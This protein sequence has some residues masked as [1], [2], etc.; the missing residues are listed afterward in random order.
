MMSPDSTSADSHA[1]RYLHII[2]QL[3][4]SDY[5]LDF[6]EWDECTPVDEALHDLAQTLASR[7]HE[8][9]QLDQIIADINT[10][11]SLDDVLDKVYAG[12]RELIP[13]DR[14]SLSL[15]DNDEDGGPFVRARWARTDHPTIRLGRGY[16]AP[17]AG[18][19][20]ETILQSGE[21]RI[22]NDLED[23]LRHKPESESTRLIVEEGIR[24]SLTCPLTI[25]GVPVGFLFFSSNE[26]NTYEHD[27][28]D[29]FL[30]IANHLAISVEKSRLV[31][32][33]TAQKNALNRQNKALQEADAI[34]NMILGIA[35]H[36]L[37]S[38]L[39]VIEMAMTFLLDPTMAAT[40][41]ESSTVLNDVLQQTRYMLDLIDELLDM[42]EVES[43][44]LRL[45]REPV[46]VHSFLQNATMRHQQT[47]H[48]KNMT[49][50]FSDN[51]PPDATLQADPLRLRQVIDNL[52]S[53]AIKYSPS[54]SVIRVGV[55]QRSDAWH[56]YV[57]D[58]GPG[59][60]AADRARLFQAFGRLSAQPT[61]G[62]R[63]TGL[64]LAIAR[65][66]VEA[67]GGRI[68]AE[69]TPGHGSTFW[70]TL[71]AGD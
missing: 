12:F 28:R 70:F 37:R 2:R 3:A 46:M 61:G 14:L 67:H 9:Q 10:S 18:S 51:L 41:E 39:G 60:K 44:Q 58:Q 45:R 54:G 13:Y 53:N 49:I 35:A 25:D 64:G 59:I 69:S 17:L 65:R 21:P 32:E 62:E 4:Q 38:P 34:K 19:S 55:E 27:H 6:S 50:S 43:G 57:A 52:L 1:D 7:Q 36:D 42:A 48:A 16:V 63:S 15:I 30:R 8:Q 29:R 71:P 23:Y 68:G 20:L 33:L 24:S 56:I 31:S 26:P 40:D 11:L 22:I 47:A 5:Q 66:V